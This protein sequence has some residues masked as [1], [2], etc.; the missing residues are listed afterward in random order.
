MPWYSWFESP[1]RTM[2]GGG[3]SRTPVL[4]RH[5]KGF[6]MLSLPLI[7]RP[8]A[9]QQTGL[10]SRLFSCWNFIQLPGN[11]RPELTWS[12]RLQP[13][14]GVKVK[15]SPTYLMRRVRTLR[16]QL[17][18]WPMINEANDHPRRATKAL[19]TQSKPISPPIKILCAKFLVAW[20][21]VQGNN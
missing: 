14:S 8:S 7:F 20:T 17:C 9:C 15:T 19:P 12:S 16:L 1:I 6:Y 18:F 11:P 3:G 4:N 13:L 10:T 21:G 5:Y 2:N